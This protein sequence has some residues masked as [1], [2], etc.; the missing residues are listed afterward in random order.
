MGSIRDEF[1]RAIGKD[2]HRR[3]KESFLYSYIKQE[4]EGHFRLQLKRKYAGLKDG[5]ISRGEYAD[6]LVKALLTDIKLQKTVWL[7]NITDTIFEGNLRRSNAGS[8]R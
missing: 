8:W 4:K 6:F 2:Y 7:L 1:Y 5:S 3:Q